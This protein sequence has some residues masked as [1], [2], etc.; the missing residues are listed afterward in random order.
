M[1]W[2]EPKTWVAGERITAA[3]LNTYVRDNFNAF[4][5]S[6]QTYT[7]AWTASTTN[8]TL[9]NGTISGRFA[10]LGKWII[11]HI[12]MV[13]GSTTTFGSG[14]YRWSV[15]RPMR[16]HGTNFG[17][18]GWWLATD[19]SLGQF[20]GMTRYLTQTTFVITGEQG[21]GAGVMQSDFTPTFP[22]TWA[23]NDQLR[24]GIFYEAD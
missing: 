1:A 8:P 13:V 22:F 2:T 11:M 16:A 6:W 14:T 21:G 15:P 5:A 19:A 12:D 24:G 17:F 18:G 7:P 20:Y 3:D 4:G 23:V 10:E 9:G